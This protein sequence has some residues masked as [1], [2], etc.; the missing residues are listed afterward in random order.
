MRRGRVEEAGALAQRIC[1]EIIRRSKTRLSHLN[2]RTGIKDIWAAVRQLTGRRQEV[3]KVDGVS[4][5]S[6][7]E[8]YALISTDGNYSTPPRKHTACNRRT[9]VVSEWRMFMILD[10]LRATAT[11]LDKLPA[12]FLRLN[13]PVFCKPLTRLFNLSIATATV[14]RQWKQASICP[15]PKIAIPSCHSDFRP[16]SITSLE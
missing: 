6:L 14:P 8:H 1:K 16:I 10:K 11:G 15:V 7:N 5:E 2:S 12:W 9:D 4:A 13:A 3:G